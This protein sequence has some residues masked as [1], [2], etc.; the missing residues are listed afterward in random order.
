MDAICISDL[1]LGSDVCQAK[2][3]EAFLKDIHHAKVKTK[4]LILNGDVFDSWDFRRL[5]KHHW[6]VLSWLR[7]LSDHVHV[8]WVAGNHDGP[9]EL[10]SHLLGVDV[11]NEYILPSGQRHILFLHGHKYDTIID[12]HPWLTYFADCGYRLLQRIDSSFALARAAKRASKVYLRNS[13]I[14]EEKAKERAKKLKC[15]SV[16]CGHTHLAAINPGDVSY[17][18][19]GCWTEKPCTFLT[20]V[21]GVVDL[22]CFE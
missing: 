22:H 1:H 21:N 18:N 13:E 7:K 15:D 2:Q 11:T 8:I 6:H 19:S 20:V 4:R 12:K 14:I 3:L 16:C 10:I 17:Y 9:A 5:Q